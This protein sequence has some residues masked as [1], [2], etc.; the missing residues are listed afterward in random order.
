MK[1]YSQQRDIKM[2][3]PSYHLRAR[4]SKHYLDSNATYLINFKS[5]VVIF[6]AALAI[7][8]PGSLKVLALLSMYLTSQTN[9][10][11]L[12]KIKK[13]CTVSTVVVLVKTEPTLF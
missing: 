13:H 11:I 12:L 9:A 7:A 2:F 3:I 8:L 5:W 1:Q 6:F 10:E 4:V